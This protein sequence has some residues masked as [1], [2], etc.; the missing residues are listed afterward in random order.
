M[1]AVIFEVE[2]RPRQAEA[3]LQLAAGL[4]PEL[5]ATDGFIEVERFASRHR[6]SRFLSLSIWRDEKALIR[7]RTQARHHSAQE[8]G[9][10]AIFADYH[11]R[12]GE[13][14]A[15]TR[16]P[17]GEGLPQQRFDE[18][19]TGEAKFATIGEFSPAVASSSADRAIAEPADLPPAG[20]QGLVDHEWF[21]SLT[22]AGKWLLIVG[23]R[24]RAAAERWYSWQVADG[25]W[26]HRIVRIIRDYGMFDRAEAPQYYPMA[27]HVL[28]RDTDK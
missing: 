23:W 1:F 26:H 3:Y 12:V 28:K 5:E 4:R 6:A 25:G 17:E 27:A 8:Q 20:T 13:I 19:E 22:N 9:R 24:D 18:S 21:E 10:A 2:P 11:L 16:R 7:W 14:L 15:D